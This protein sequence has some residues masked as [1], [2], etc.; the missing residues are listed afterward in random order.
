MAANTCHCQPRKWRASRLRPQDWKSGERV[1]PNERQL[2]V[3]DVIALSAC[4]GLRS[5]CRAEDMVREFKANIF[6]TS[7][8]RYLRMDAEGKNKRSRHAPSHYADSI[9]SNE[10]CP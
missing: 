8:I 4:P 5:G 6:P 7:E 9:F 1:P 10:K 3:V 2:W